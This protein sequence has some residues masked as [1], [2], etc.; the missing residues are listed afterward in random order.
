MSS[1]ASVWY[2]MF[3][4]NWADH[5][6]YFSKT[7]NKKCES[8][9]SK[10]Q[11]ARIRQF[12]LGCLFRTINFRGTWWPATI[13]SRIHLL[14]QPVYG[15]TNEWTKPPLIICSPINFTGSCLQGIT[16]SFTDMIDIRIWS[17]W[18]YCNWSQ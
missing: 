9:K 1:F 11:K 12:T 15:R 10:W 18:L 7:M 5:H 17:S 8:E 14:Q 13:F 6:A 2:P 16:I 4:P 3:S